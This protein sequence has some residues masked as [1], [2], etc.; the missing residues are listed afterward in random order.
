MR[1][2][3]SKLIF[4][5]AGVTGFL[6][7]L[8]ASLSAGQSFYGTSD[9]KVFRQGRDAEFRKRPESPLLDVDFAKFAGLNYFPP[10]KSY[11]ISASIRITDEAKFFMM[12]TSSGKPKKFRKFGVLTFTLAG[13]KLSLSVYQADAEF[14]KKFPEFAGLLFIPFRD[15]TNGNETYGG[16]RYT[17]IKMPTGNRVILD[18][19]LSYNPNC[20]YGSDKY[21]CPIPPKENELAVAIR[22]GERKFEHSAH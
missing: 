10:N 2:S 20:A 17:G 1:R 9:V 6:I 11:R 12:P 8:F 5:Q 16:G 4:M 18:F 3:L 13:R 22:A 14:L 19:N 21:S 15:N 7:F